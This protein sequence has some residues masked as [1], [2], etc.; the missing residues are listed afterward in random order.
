MDEAQI[1]M[2]IIL[3]A[4]QDAAVVLQPGKQALDLPAAAVAPQGAPILRRRPG[5]VAFMRGDHLNA[6]SREALVQRITV[7]R[8]V[9]N[10]PVGLGGG[11][12]LRE[13]GVDQGDFMGCSRRCVVP[14]SPL[15]HSIYEMAS[16]AFL[17]ISDTSGEAGGTPALPAAAP[18]QYPADFAPPPMTHNRMKLL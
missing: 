6:K 17:V 15:C 8:P 9:P 13:R 1:V 3:K 12:P 18:A 10:Q 5:P 4:R 11:E 2:G 14:C 7:I 16:R